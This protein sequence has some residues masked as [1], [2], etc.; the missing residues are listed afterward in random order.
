MRERCEEPRRVWIMLGVRHHSHHGNSPLQDIFRW[1]SLTLRAATCWLCYWLQWMWWWSSRVRLKLPH[2]IFL[3][4]R[5][6]LSLP[7]KVRLLQ[8]EYKQGSKQ[9]QWCQQGRT[10][11]SLP[12]HGRHPTECSGCCHWSWLKGLPTLPRWCLR[13]PK[14]WHQHWSC[15]DRCRLWLRRGARLLHHQKLLGQYLGRIRIHQNSSRWRWWCLWYYF[16]TSVCLA[17][18]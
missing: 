3:R 5:V 6:C 8:L 7:G 12:A 1:S 11:K 18:C 17:N 10:R 2:K 15:S 9:M 14:M 16:R 4:A 13:R